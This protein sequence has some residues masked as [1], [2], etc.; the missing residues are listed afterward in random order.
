SAM[1]LYDMSFSIESSWCRVDLRGGIPGGDSMPGM[2]S[3]R[4]HA[5]ARG[6]YDAVGAA[7]PDVIGLLGTARYCAPAAPFQFC[8]VNSLRD[9]APVS[10]SLA[11]GSALLRAIGILLRHRSSRSSH[12][13]VAYA[14]PLREADHQS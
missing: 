5:G 9:A 14:N 2:P 3:R 8:R 10:R 13:E 4:V 1:N 7:R 12:R 11:S 6:A